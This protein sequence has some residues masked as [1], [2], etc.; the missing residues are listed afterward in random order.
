MQ[1]LNPNQR[2]ARRRPIGSASISSVSRTMRRAR[3]PTAALSLAPRRVQP[4][5]DQGTGN[6]DEATST[7]ITSCT[8][9]LGLATACSRSP[10]AAR[11]RRRHRL[12]RARRCRARA[13]LP[14]AHPGSTCALARARRFESG[15]RCCTRA[16]SGPFRRTCPA[17]GRACPRSAS[18]E[19]P[20]TR[21]R[22]ENH[23]GNEDEADAGGCELPNGVEIRVADREPE[24]DRADRQAG[25]ASS[26]LP[27]FPLRP[28]MRRR[29]RRFRS[30]LLSSNVEL[31]PVVRKF[32]LVRCRQLTRP[33][34]NEEPLAPDAS[35]ASTASS[36]DRCP[37]GSPS[38][39]PR[40]RVASQTKR[41]ASRAACTSSGTVRN[42][43]ST[44]APRPFDCTRN[45]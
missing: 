22:A 5:E 40:S 6:H 34:R 10:G 16:R 14:S 25:G 4:G 13:R 8:S 36:S 29:Y 44:R 21:S 32:V 45:A 12:G 23:D 11:A 19:R 15:A 27:S 9:Q 7:P 28:L 37:R 38:S 42:R 20:G 43:P 17:P 33:V 18:T 39:S 3:L 41:S 31:E 1:K 2:A 24:E 26:P 35:N 30:V